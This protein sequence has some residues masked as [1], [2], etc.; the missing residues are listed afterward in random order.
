MKHRSL[1]SSHT[2][3]ARTGRPPRLQHL[4][5]AAVVG[6]HPLE[7]VEDQGVDGAGLKVPCGLAQLRQYIASCRRLTIRQAAA[8]GVHLREGREGCDFLGFH[9][10]WVRAHGRYPHVRFLARLP[11]RQAIQQARDQIREPAD[12]HGCCCRST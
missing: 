10:R 4:G 11:S 2:G 5:V 1:A 12:A 7:Q 9:H 8:V 6:A 3:R